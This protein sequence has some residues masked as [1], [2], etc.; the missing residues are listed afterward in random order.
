[1]FAKGK[2]AYLWVVKI[3]AEVNM[4]FPLSLLS[5]IFFSSICSTVLFRTVLGDVYP[6]KKS[7]LREEI[8]R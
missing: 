3:I 7:D 6:P 5:T 2:F 4:K 8:N 1:V